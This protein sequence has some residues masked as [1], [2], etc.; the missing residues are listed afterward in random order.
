[1]P[2]RMGYSSRRYNTAVVTLLQPTYVRVELL[3]CFM[4]G[5]QLALSVST[6]VYNVVH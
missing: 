2:T 4:S 6:L 1:M 5:L 3:V